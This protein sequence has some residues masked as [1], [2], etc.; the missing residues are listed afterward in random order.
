MPDMPTLE[1]QVFY[2]PFLAL[3]ELKPVDDTRK[4]TYCIGTLIDRSTIVSTTECLGA[5]VQ[6]TGGSSN[7]VTLDSRIKYRALL[8]NHDESQN[9]VDINDMAEY[10]IVNITVVKFTHKFN[11]ISQLEFMPIRNLINVETHKQ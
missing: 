6:P 10:N 1:Y 5:I 9:S 8:V 11:N 3:I 2:L 7:R 4:T